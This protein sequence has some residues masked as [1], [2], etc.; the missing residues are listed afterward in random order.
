MEVG[1]HSR[2]VDIDLRCFLRGVGACLAR[3][4]GALGNGTGTDSA[5]PPP[6]TPFSPLPAQPFNP[7]KARFTLFRRVFDDTFSSRDPSRIDL[8]RATLNLS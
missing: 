8:R 1:A 4:S 7:H 5:E 2:P 6:I 3:S